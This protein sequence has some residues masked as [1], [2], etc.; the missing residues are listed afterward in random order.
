M[1]AQVS[2]D[3]YLHYIDHGFFCRNNDLHRKAPAGPRKSL[4]DGRFRD[5][6][7]KKILPP[8][9]TMCYAF[10][11][12]IPCDSQHVKN[13]SF[14]TNAAQHSVL[15]Y[16]RASTARANA[17]AVLR[18]L[19]LFLIAH[20]NPPRAIREKVSRHAH[21]RVRTAIFCLRV[22]RGSRQA[23]DFRTAAI[24]KQTDHR[25]KA[26]KHIEG[27]TMAGMGRVSAI[28]ADTIACIS[29]NVRACVGSSARLSSPVS[30][31]VLCLGRA[32]RSAHAFP[33][34]SRS[35]TPPPCG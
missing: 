4:G 17:I 14:I 8:L 20:G 11:L 6:R 22:G 31:L 30:C 3:S 7:T 26:R 1:A 12:E 35:A 29:S 28:D 10:V 15:P 27:T 21:P 25:A 18:S 24:R 9:G 33:T 32:S 19:V 23:T 5:Q 34:R 13:D 16:A 2:N